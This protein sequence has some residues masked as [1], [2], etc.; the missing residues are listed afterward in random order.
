MSGAHASNAAEYVVYVDTGEKGKHRYVRTLDKDWR[1]QYWTVCQ[2]CAL[3]MTRGEAHHAH[4]G[5]D[6]YRVLRLRP[7]AG[8]R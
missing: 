2:A 8:E 7:K 6:S 5:C 4:V 1:A 3:R